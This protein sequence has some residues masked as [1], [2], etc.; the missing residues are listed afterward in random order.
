MLSTLPPYTASEHAQSGV[1]ASC[2]RGGCLLT[3]LWVL[4]CR[5]L[6]ARQLRQERNTSVLNYEVRTPYTAQ[7]G[8]ALSGAHG[9]PCRCEDQP[10]PSYFVAM[11]A[12]SPRGQLTHAQR[13]C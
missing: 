11:L 10:S 5:H 8:P 12:V 9:Q 1:S 4:A 2:C 13:V 7:L 6:L 3:P